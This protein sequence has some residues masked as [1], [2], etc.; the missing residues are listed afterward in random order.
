[1]YPDI[2]LTFLFTLLGTLSHNVYIDISGSDKIDCGSR[3]QPY[4]SLSYT[5]N[6]VSRPYDKI[7][8]IASPIKQI[9]YTLEKQIVMKH[10]LT[11]TKYPLFT[12]NP[13]IIYGD[14]VTRNWKEF[15]AFAKFRSAAAAPAGILSLKIKSVNFNVNIFTAFSEEYKTIGKG[16][17][18]YAS[19][20]L[21]SLLISDSIISSP[22]IAVNLSDA[23]GSENVSIHV[24]D[25]IIQS[26]RFIFN[27][28]K[29]AVDPRN[30][31]KIL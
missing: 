6:H 17:F 10:S 29:K 13:V 2:L 9:K 5:I 31:L 1:M 22:S 7:C 4:R 15:Y 20:C 3:A 28:K 8:L 30:T 12:A 21:V 14:N 24:E 18:E 23:S 11:V 16:T 19:G 26:G 27:N 25:S